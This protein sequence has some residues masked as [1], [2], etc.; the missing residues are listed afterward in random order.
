MIP[1]FPHTVG[2]ETP[3]WGES[4]PTPWGGENSGCF[5]DRFGL[6]PND[7]FRLN[8]VTQVKQIFE[9]YYEDNNSTYG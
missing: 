9:K 4:F 6:N 5:N 7:R 1:D 2:N 8:Y 3:H